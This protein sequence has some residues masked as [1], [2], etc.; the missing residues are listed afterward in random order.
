MTLL[1]TVAVLSI[2]SVA[3]PIPPDLIVLF[4]LFIIDLGIFLGLALVLFIT[5]L[6]SYIDITHG[7]VGRV[8][9]P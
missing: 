7:S 6:M 3:L 1:S 5:H 8:Q 2:I 9:P 4:I